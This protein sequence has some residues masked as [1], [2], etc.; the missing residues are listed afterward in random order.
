MKFYVVETLTGK[1]RG[2]LHPHAWSLSD[3]LREVGTGT[4]TLAKPHVNDTLRDLVWP[5]HSDGLGRTGDRWVAAQDDTG[6][7]VWSGP[8]LSRP[9]RSDSSVTIKLADWR[10][11]FYRTPLRPTPGDYIVKARDQVTIGKELLE[12]AV[13]DTTASTTL[14]P[15]PF[16]VA[17]PAVSGVLR[18]RTLR[19]LDRSTGDHMDDLVNI[20]RGLEW[21]TYCA[22]SLT[23]PTVLEL[24]VTTAYPERFKRSSGPVRVEWQHGKGGNVA[25]QPSW[26]ETGETVTRMWATG[27]GEPPAQAFS[28]SEDSD[29]SVLW[30]GSV[31]PLDG[32]ATA[33]AAY[34]H[35]FAER[36]RAGGH[37]ANAEFVL[38]SR[39]LP[40]NDVGPGDRARVIYDD[41]WEAYDVPAARI[42]DRVMSGGRGV[43][44][45]HRLVIDL[46]DV[47]EPEL[48]DPGTP[49]IEEA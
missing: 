1:I 47:I 2:Q 46:S 18:D 26:P 6:A 15:P 43:P 24:F 17:T 49:G 31:G 45:L 41:G 11:W 25:E 7:F 37:A 30:E 36:V 32:V 13:T 8:I 42:V 3:P 19:R 40:F 48:D 35:A 34:S 5:R 21:W 33:G 23:D 28:R 38:T 29:A 16:K 9:L 27:D 39:R 20:E 14:L 22:P 10:T 44:E 12:R 4:L